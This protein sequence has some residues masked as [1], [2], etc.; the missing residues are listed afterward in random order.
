MRRYVAVLTIA[1][2]SAPSVLLA[3]QREP[4]SEAVPD[5]ADS[6]AL[7]DAAVETPQS[8]REGHAPRSLMGM[9]MGALIE[10]AEQSARRDAL[11]RTQAK[12]TQL[13]PRSSR[14]LVQSP[15]VQSDRAIHEEIAVQS[16]P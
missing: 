3:Q 12:A 8:M 1:L 16:P 7:Q 11:L 5:N 10:S 9:V 6:A 2:L 13:S 15:L 4:A 14:P